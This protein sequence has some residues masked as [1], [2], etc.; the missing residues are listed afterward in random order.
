MN[1]KWLFQVFTKERSALRQPVHITMAEAPDVSAAAGQE[2]VE[3][4]YDIELRNNQDAQVHVVA[5][6]QS[7]H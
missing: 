4:K 7:G 6:S 2:V 5:L 3:D 1:N